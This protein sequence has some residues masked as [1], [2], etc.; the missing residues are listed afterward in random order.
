MLVFFGGRQFAIE[1][2]G[3]MLQSN[4]WRGNDVLSVFLRR[5]DARLGYEFV[6]PIRLRF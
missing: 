5:K 6:W 3:R 1:I 2:V 4:T